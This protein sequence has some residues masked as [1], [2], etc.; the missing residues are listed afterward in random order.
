MI[1]RSTFIA[2]IFAAAA[3]IVQPAFSAETTRRFAASDSSKQRIAIINQKGDIEWEYK[4]GPLHDLHVLPSGNVLFQTSM[5]RLLE[6]DPKTDKIVWEYDAAVS[7]G[8]KGRPVQ[9]HAF[10]RLADGVTMI[11]ESGPARII[12]VDSSGKLLKEIALKVDHPHVHR[13][14]RLARKIDNGNYLVCH[15]ADGTVREYDSSGKVVWSYEVPL[16]GKKPKGG[17]GLE[18]FGNQCFSVLRLKNGNT[19]IGTGNGHSILEVT[20][21]KKVV[22]SIH[23]NDL[24]GIQLAWV[25]SL[26]VLPSGNILVGNCH[27]GPDNPQLIEVTR[28]KKVVWKFHDFNRFGNA[29]TNSQIL[30]D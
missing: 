1:L 19:L 22:W 3:T 6:V 26:Q 13:D 21:D 25:T 11:A 10:Q 28:D 9:V 18:A 5:T 16:F 29:L 20:P 12:E 30:F 2:L 24:D 14:T 17:H 23:Q 7:N 27:A 8:N 4:I 15:E